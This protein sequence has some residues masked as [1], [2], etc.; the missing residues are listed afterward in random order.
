[1]RI[2]LLCAVVFLLSLFKVTTFSAPF[3]MTACYIAST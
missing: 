3:C 2:G 1:V